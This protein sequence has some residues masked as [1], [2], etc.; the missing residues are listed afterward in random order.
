MQNLV[1]IRVFNITRTLVIFGL[2]FFLVFV[3]SGNA[4]GLKQPVV[5]E[6]VQKNCTAK[7]TDEDQDASLI[8]TTRIRDL[9]D[10]WNP[11]FSIGRLSSVH[12]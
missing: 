2:I 6:S 12:F 10:K 9:T 11:V 1:L 3:R 8:D 7:Q 5:C 4:D